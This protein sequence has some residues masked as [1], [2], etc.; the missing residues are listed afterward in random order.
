MRPRKI[1]KCFPRWLVQFTYFL[2]ILFH[3]QRDD[4]PRSW[5]SCVGTVRVFMNQ[6]LEPKVDLFVDILVHTIAVIPLDE[7]FG[8]QVAFNRVEGGRKWRP[9]YLSPET[10]GESTTLSLVMQASIAKA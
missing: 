4:G 2:E 1:S 9:V 10:V 3:G 7:R 6:F 8:A 5:R